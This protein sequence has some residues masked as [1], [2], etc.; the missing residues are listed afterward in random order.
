MHEIGM[1]DSVLAAVER[2]AAGRPVAGLTVRVGALLRVVPE[3][4][5][6]SFE[7]VAAGS[8]ADGA[9]PELVIVP[10][11]G[12]CDD[13][14]TGFESDDPMPIC[15]ACDSLRVTRTGGDELVL[16]SI[17]YHAAAPAERS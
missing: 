5:A 1:C 9:T 4:F 15:P 10:V 12:V 8:V 17:R 11:R 2:R 14:G 6:Q 16:E 3:A 7:L 13:C